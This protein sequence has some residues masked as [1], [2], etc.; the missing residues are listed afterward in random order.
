MKLLRRNLTEF[1]YL[2]NT[3]LESDLNEDEEHTGEFYPVYGEPVSYKG[4]ISSPSGYTNQAFYGMD[5]RYTHVLV[6]DNPD[7]DIRETGLIRWKGEL[8]DIRAVKPSLNVLSV[9]LR[10]QTMHHPDGDDDEQ[11]DP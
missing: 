6:M 10:K 2:P 3:G 5:I 11:Q 8:Y 7:L 4:N 9:A 1:E